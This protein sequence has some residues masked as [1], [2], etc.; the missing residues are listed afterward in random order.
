MAKSMRGYSG[1]KFGGKHTTVIDAACSVVEAAVK[2]PEVRTISPGYITMGLRAAGH[3]IKF[4]PI[5]GGLMVRVR[6]TCCI[7]EIRVYTTNPGATE[8]ALR[9]A[10]R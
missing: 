3:H 4:Q 6:G 7:Q 8:Q 9:G 2:Q 1:P 5:T 10:F